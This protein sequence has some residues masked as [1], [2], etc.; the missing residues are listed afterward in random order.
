MQWV[1]QYALTVSMVAS[2]L[3][4]L[5]VCAL[6]AIYGLSPRE[7]QPED[8][9]RRQYRTTLGRGAAA[10]SF[11]V[12]ATAAVV[13]LTASPVADQPRP[14]LLALGE[15]LAAVATALDRI[16]SAA[17]Q[18]ATGRDRRMMSAR[19]A[20]RPEAE[21]PRSAAALERVGEPA[22]EGGRAGASR[23]TPRR[24]ARKDSSGASEART[25]PP[26]QPLSSSSPVAEE[27]EQTPE[28]TAGLRGADASRE[29]DPS[30]SPLSSGTTTADPPGGSR[31][32]PLVDEPVGDRF[33]SVSNV[34]PTEPIPDDAHSAPPPTSRPEPV[35]V[36]TAPPDVRDA[37]P[38]P[39]CG[40]ASVTEAGYEEAGD[41]QPRTQG[42]ANCVGGWLKGEVDEFRDGVKREIG[43]FRAGFD[44]V[45]RA[46]QRFCSKVCN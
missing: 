40:R 27:A 26:R 6:I 35:T 13:A 32:S 3:G 23:R 46:L 19:P 24:E 5:I 44:T 16:D 12:A 30:V 43:E 38:A 41:G 10:A 20:A 42:L 18:L 22:A 39:G 17:D 34:T 21:A 4:A 9:D 15:R 33:N 25:P 29:T 37:G 28:V 2:V 14:S 36:A 11:T 31:A 7:G 8:D 1:V 45:R